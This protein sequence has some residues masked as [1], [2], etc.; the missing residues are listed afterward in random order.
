V[1]LCSE[2]KAE[3]LAV[4]DPS[5]NFLEEETPSPGNNSALVL[6]ALLSLATSKKRTIYT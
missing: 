6:A 3:P 1:N 4:F 2:K 5:G